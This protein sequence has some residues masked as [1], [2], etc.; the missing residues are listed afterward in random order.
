VP[1]Q[2]WRLAVGHPRAGHRASRWCCW[3]GREIR[4]GDTGTS[5][6]WRVCDHVIA[7]AVVG[8]VVV[9]GAPSREGRTR[10]TGQ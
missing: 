6:G 1:A 3:A 8:L 5:I 4:L 10:V 9:P 7:K 2:D